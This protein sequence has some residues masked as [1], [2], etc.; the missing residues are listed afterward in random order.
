MEYFHVYKDQKEDNNE[1]TG[2]HHLDSTIINILPNTLYPWICLSHAYIH[3][4]LF[5]GQFQR[6][7]Q[8]LCIRGLNRAAC[9]RICCLELTTDLR[10]AP[11]FLCVRVT[12]L[13]DTQKWVA[14][15]IQW[16][17]VK[18]MEF[19]ILLWDHRK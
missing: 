11:L 5:I 2:V 19:S 6:K 14:L 1:H 9:F 3:I 7:L 15:I 4:Y 13:E 8:I 10:Y 17:E 16:S 18:A 12:E